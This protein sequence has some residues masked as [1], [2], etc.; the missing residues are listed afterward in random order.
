VLCM[1]LHHN[2]GWGHPQH[3]TDL[4][5]I[6]CAKTFRDENFLIVYK[7][8]LLYCLVINFS[9]TKLIKI[10]GRT[11]YL[12]LI[13]FQTVISFLWLSRTPR[14]NL[15]GQTQ[16]MTPFTSRAGQKGQAGLKEEV[17]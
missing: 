11:K 17:A 4:Q 2:S 12:S 3:K 1:P 13:G 9:L 10:F 16:I 5:E 15:T 8:S 7:K 6:D 14:P